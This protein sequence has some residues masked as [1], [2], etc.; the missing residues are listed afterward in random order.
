V[1]RVLHVAQPVDGGVGRYVADL[2]V[3]Q[4]AAGWAVAVACPPGQLADEVAAA[5]VPWV[6]WRAA[7]SPGPSVPAETRSLGRIIDRCAPAAVHLH[8]SKAGLAGRLA[9]RGRRVTL[10]QPHGW[11]WQAG[12][13]IVGTAATR[14]ERWAARWARVV[15]CV[16]EAE[17]VAGVQ[18]GV[19]AAYDVVPNGVDL[20]RFT[21]A[22]AA[23]RAAARQ[24]LDLPPEAPIALCVGR[25]DD[26]KGQATLIGA[27][28]A[29]LRA[30]PDS[31]LVFVGDGPRRGELESLA[32]R[33][34]PGAVRFA[35]ARPDVPRWYAAAD[36]V[37]LSS[38]WGEAMALTPLEAM[39]CGRPVVASDVAGVRES[40]GAGCG[41]IVPPGDESAFAAALLARLTDPELAAREGAAGRAHAEQALDLRGVHA[42]LMNLI[43]GLIDHS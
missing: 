29:V 21:P 42:Y 17:R 15:L 16:S 30:A 14:W 8:S 10:F 20:D 25:L 33:G 23:E 4:H 35:G 31:L 40:L 13:G 37:A 18:H 22:A 27:W 38:R 5:G 6:Q 7:R 36:V 24:A 11:A 26:Q 19:R 1:T 2:A 3:A 39:A 28:S 32:G 41:A 43:D 9:L 12:G 34:A